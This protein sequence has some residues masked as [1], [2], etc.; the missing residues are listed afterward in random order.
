MTKLFYSYKWKR[1]IIVT[2]VKSAFFQTEYLE[3]KFIFLIFA[4]RM[5]QIYTKTGDCGQTSLRGGM[6]VDKDDI[7]IET[8]GEI[9]HLNA[10]LGV[11]RGSVSVPLLRQVQQELMIVMSHVATPDG[12]ENPK[13]LHVSAL[14]VD[15]ERA[16]DELTEGKT[17]GFVLPGDNHETAFLHVARTQCRLVERRLWTLNR[18]YKVNPEILKFI[19]RLSDYLFALSL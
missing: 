15:M 2:Y 19:N 16:I 4:P 14:T 17:L 12:C 3:R 18:E 1:S 13:E 10:L 5:K 7:R 11:V 9:D 8:N 6:R